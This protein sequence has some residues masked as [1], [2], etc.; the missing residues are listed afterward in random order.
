[1]RKIPVLLLAF[2][3]G[4]WY[5]RPNPWDTSSDR[6]DY[7]DLKEA[8]WRLELQEPYVFPQHPGFVMALP[9]L[10]GWKNSV[11]LNADGLVLTHMRDQ[12][13]QKAAGL[14]GRAMSM[15]PMNENNKVQIYELLWE[16]HVERLR[17]HMIEERLAVVNR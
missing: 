10:E 13:V 1:M 14:E 17:L 16:A 15:A 11:L 3:G 6:A 8:D 4:C 9:D 2:L 5:D 7:L 12:S